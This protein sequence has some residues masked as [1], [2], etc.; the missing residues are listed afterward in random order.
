MSDRRHQGPEMLQKRTPIT[1]V[2]QYLGLEVQYLGLEVLHSVQTAQ[3]RGWRHNPPEWVGHRHH[4]SAQIGNAD[5]AAADIECAL[6]EAVPAVELL[7]DILEELAGQWELIERPTGHTR[8][9]SKCKRILEARGKIE[10][11]LQLKGLGCRSEAQRVDDRP[12]HR[13][14]YD[15]P[16]GCRVRDQPHCLR[17]GASVLAECEGRIQQDDTADPL[18]MK[19]GKDRR[20][21]TTKRVAGDQWPGDPDLS[22][23]RRKGSSG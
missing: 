16:D 8:V 22:F 2:D 6:P 18:R 17:K 20:E 7:E 15:L 1:L 10:S 3:K 21:G 5:V 4:R 14:G 12:W 19:R 11:R 13:A 23:D 9:D